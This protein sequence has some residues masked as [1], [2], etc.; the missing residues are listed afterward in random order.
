MTAQDITTKVRAIMNEAGAEETLTLLSEDTVKL[1]TYIESVIP[2]ASNLILSVA[3]VRY[4]NTKSASPAT[5]IVAGSTFIPLPED[6]SR[7]A[8]VQLATWTRAVSEVLLLNSIE[9]K[10][11]K[12]Q[13][14]KPGINKPLCFFSYNGTDEALECIPSSTLSQF[15]YVPTISTSAEAVTVL[16]Q[17]LFLPVCYMAASLVYNIFENQPM[18]NNMKAVVTDLLKQL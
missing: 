13:F 3:P 4:I 2:D 5:A 10:V 11:A 17:E 12:N 18:S 9:Y 14:T 16:K 6:F 1:D 8:Y 7:L 15:I